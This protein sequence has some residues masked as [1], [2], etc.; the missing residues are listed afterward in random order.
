MC[1]IGFFSLV[2]YGQQSTV[3]THKIPQTVLV[4]PSL[5]AQAEKIQQKEAQLSQ[6]TTITRSQLAQLKEELAALNSEYKVLLSNQIQLTTDEATRKEL[7]SELQ[8][9]EQQLAGINQR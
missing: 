3:A 7:E 9:V 2:S 1:S 8:Y 6:A 4:T 5:K